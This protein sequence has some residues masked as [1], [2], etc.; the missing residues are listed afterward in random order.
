MSDNFDDRLR[1]RLD[2]LNTDL[3]GV[4]L[5]GPAAARRRAAQRTRNQIT[6][7]ALAGVAVI[8][9][10]F[11]GV[12]QDSL[13]SAPEPAGT[14]TPTTVPSPDETA[15]P[16]QTDDATPPPDGSTV[17]ESAFLT[18]EDITP[19]L[20]AGDEFPEWVEGDAREVPFDCAPA[21]PDGAAYKYFSNSD[22]GYFLQ[23]IE[24]T[25]DPVGRFSQL[26]ADMESCIR[27]FEEEAGDSD[28]PHTQFSQVWA[29]DGLGDEAWMAHY[30][31]RLDE[32]IDFANAH[33]VAVRLV[34]TGNHITMVIDGGPGQDDNM[35]MAEE[36]S[37]LA[38][39]RLC[40][41]FGTECV[42]EVSKRRLDQE[43]VGDLAGWLT[44]EDIASIPGYDTVVEGDEP[45]DPTEDGPSGWPLHNLVVDPV[46]AGASSLLTRAYVPEEPADGPLLHQSI[47]R[48]PDDA[49]ARA[50]YDDLVSAADEF[51]QE[52]DE[53]TNTGSVD[54]DDYSLT[55]WR[56]E[57]D[58]F[59]TVFVYGAVVQG[60]EMSVVSTGF[61]EFEDRD[62]TPEQLTELLV[63]AADHLRDHQGSS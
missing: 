23:F 10:G 31:S 61:S 21:V 13:F 39:Q 9:A 50:H 25:G 38:A 56:S 36:R 41:A 24:E 8:V 37:E 59:N 46:A 29:V 47:A 17:P 52:G 22:D 30:W 28:E 6:G 33:L 42:G 44:V 14:E 11:I 60:S 35:N 27:E 15:D 45:L 1:N 62:L 58:E 54:G 19:E 63:R 26:R 2:S 48:F 55:T 7:V 20:E 32:P 18:T 4:R 5:D 51:E 12:T 57:N 49:A 16:D 34:R 40:D 43:P 3:S 53:V